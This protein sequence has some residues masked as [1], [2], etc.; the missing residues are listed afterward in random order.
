MAPKPNKKTD[1]DAEVVPKKVALP[2][3]SLA[4]EQYIGDLMRAAGEGRM[5]ALLEMVAHAVQ[6]PRYRVDMREAALADL[7]FENVMFA[8]TR[9]W[10]AEKTKYFLADMTDLYDLLRASSDVCEANLFVK[11]C[12]T[13]HRSTAL[14]LAPS[15]HDLEHTTPTDTTTVFSLED[16]AAIAEH[17]ASGAIQHHTLYRMVFTG[18]RLSEQTSTTTLK[19]PLPMEPLPL[20]MA[21]TEEAFTEHEEQRK[22]AYNDA[23]KEVRGKEEDARVALAEAKK[24]E[25]EAARLE[26]EKEEEERAAQLSLGDEETAAAVEAVRADIKTSLAARHTALMERLARIEEEVAAS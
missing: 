1:G 12:L 16:L 24:A 23:V 9:G 17:T 15:S 2:E 21:M 8:H 13:S 3:H 19:I 25:E 10:G 11:K 7:H 4:S 18:A 20:S 22:V 26:A 14:K 6:C 5:E